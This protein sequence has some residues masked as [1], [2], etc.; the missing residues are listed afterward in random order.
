MAGTVCKNATHDSTQQAVQRVEVALTTE[1]L[2]KCKFSK[3]LPFD[4]LKMYEHHA[5]TV[6]TDLMKEQWW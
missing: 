2:Q 5:S 1:N 6:G 3:N 4:M